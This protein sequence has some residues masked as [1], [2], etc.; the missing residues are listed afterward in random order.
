[1]KYKIVMSLMLL[2]SCTTY[3]QETKIEAF[4]AAFHVGESVMICGKLVQLKHLDNR[5]YLNLDKSYPN[6]TLTILVWDN[7][8]RW[9]ESRFGNLDS[10]KGSRICARGVIEQYKN[11]LQI[12]VKNPQFLRLMTQ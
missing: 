9:F 6:Q 4:K 10:M 11:S 3:A 5:H 7:D 2:A 12:E 8:Y 1:M